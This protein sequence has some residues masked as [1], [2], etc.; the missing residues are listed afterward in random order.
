MAS[1]PHVRCVVCRSLSVVILRLRNDYSV[2]LISAVTFRRP[3]WASPSSLS[4][5]SIENNGKATANTHAARAV[6]RMY[7]PL[8]FRNKRMC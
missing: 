5:W 1:S 7:F 8:S 2:Q 4:S 6:V 3:Y